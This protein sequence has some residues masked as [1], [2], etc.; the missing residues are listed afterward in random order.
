MLFYG[1]AS[2][3]HY[4]YTYLWLSFV[5]ISMVD[6][7]NVFILILPKLQMSFCQQAGRTDEFINEYF[8]SQKYSII[9]FMQWKTSTLL[10]LSKE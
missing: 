10:K 3:E 5:T 6:H 9:F 2:V 7:V 4:P 8:N 1:F